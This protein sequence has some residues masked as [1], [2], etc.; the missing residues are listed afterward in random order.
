MLSSKLSRNFDQELFKLIMSMR[1]GLPFPVLRKEVA[2]YI[3]TLTPE[4]RQEYIDRRDEILDEWSE[5]KESNHWVLM[6]IGFNDIEA[7][8]LD[9]KRLDS[10]G[11]RNVLR[12]RAVELGYGRF[13]AEGVFKLVE[14]RG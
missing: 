14:R 1:E 6:R 2:K 7:D 12:N 8:L 9:D 4:Q 3:K 5:W 10:P 13:V 11:V